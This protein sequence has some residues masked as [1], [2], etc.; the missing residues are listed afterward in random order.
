MYSPQGWG[1]DADDLDLD[2]DNND[3]GDDDDDG[4]WGDDWNAQPVKKATFS[5]KKFETYES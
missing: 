1:D 2:G 4:D 5:T 3:N